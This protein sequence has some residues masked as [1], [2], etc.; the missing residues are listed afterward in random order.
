MPNALIIEG[1]IRGDKIYSL[2]L[3]M[4]IKFVFLYYQH[5]VE[6]VYDR[7]NKK[8]FRI[9]FF[10]NPRILKTAVNGFINDY[11]ALIKGKIYRK[12]HKLLIW[13]T[14]NFKCQQGN[15]LTLVLTNA[16]QVC[17]IVGVAGF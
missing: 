4:V 5:R 17:F 13:N 14:G 10:Y 6:K 12:N 16:G 9:T 8:L 3:G 2:L 1:I 15:L 11:D 7:L